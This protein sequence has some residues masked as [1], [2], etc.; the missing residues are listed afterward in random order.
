[1]PDSDDSRKLDA[2]FLDF[3]KELPSDY[4]EALERLIP[5][6]YDEL[7]QIA[8]QRLSFERNDHT[9]NTT[10]LVHE[11]Y[12]KLAKR[13]TEWQSRG[14]FLATAS[15]I[16]RQLLINYA[17]KRNAKKRGGGM[18]NVPL[19][20]VPEVIT[21]ERAEMLLSLDE[22]LQK[23]AEFDKRGAQIIEY[24]FFGGLS[25]VEIAK[26]L[27]VTERTVRRSWVMAKT[28]IQQEMQNPEILS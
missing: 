15:K 4:Q 6:L 1:M 28:W 2:S 24:R 18:K 16:M 11:V 12:I 13:E 8:H 26:L 9:L 7:R 27:G 23:L 19:D 10:A 14:H 5:I 3:L 21:N 22:A 25:Q 17:E 20:D